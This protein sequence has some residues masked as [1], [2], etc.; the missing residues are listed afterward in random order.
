[1][2]LPSGYSLRSLRMIKQQNKTEVSNQI[3]IHSDTLRN[4]EEGNIKNL[5]CTH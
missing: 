1:M 3:G 2:Y 5:V 4:N